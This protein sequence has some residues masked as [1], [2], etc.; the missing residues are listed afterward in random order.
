[1][2]ASALAL[3]NN[4]CVF[5]RPFP[6]KHFPVMSL[7]DVL[8][9]DPAPLK[10]PDGT[11]VF[12][13]LR[14]DGV[15]GSGTASDPY[16]GSTTYGRELSCKL[17]VEG[18]VFELPPEFPDANAV[19]LLAGGATDHLHQ[20]AIIRNNL[21]RFVDGQ[22]ST[23]A[24]HLIGLE[25]VRNVIIS[26]NVVSDITAPD[27]LISTSNCGTVTCFDNRTA[28]GELVLPDSDNYVPSLDV[29]ADDTLALAA[30]EK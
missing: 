5:V 3:P 23:E 25:W 22:E 16:D 27:P 7:M 17:L 2:R 11:A 19:L 30:F 8:L 4:R 10:T 18:N 12:V 9:L 20:Q 24:A 13:A 14:K 29:P 15:L 28:E 21:F 26:G 1:M 6:V